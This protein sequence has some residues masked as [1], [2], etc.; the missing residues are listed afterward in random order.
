VENRGSLTKVCAYVL[1]NV[2]VG[3]SAAVTEAVKQLGVVE[4]A[5]TVTG[6]YDVVAVLNV[7]GLKELGSVVAEKIHN[8]DGVSSTVTCIVVD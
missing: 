5:H 3:K 2:K 8:I 6:I 1:I 7:Q 4:S